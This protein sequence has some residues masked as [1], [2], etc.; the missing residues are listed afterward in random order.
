MEILRNIV[1]LL[2]L[3]GFAL[4]FGGWVAQIVRRELSVSLIM[5][6]GLTTQL[7]TGLILAIP[8]PEGIEL[9]YVKLAVKLGIL[10]VIGG[11]FGVLITRERRGMQ[12]LLA[13]FWSIGVLAFANA[14]IAILWR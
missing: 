12:V 1:V 2:H 6:I 4:L 7:V 13:M 3:L 10:I 11:A 9:N 8:F 14:A 5:R